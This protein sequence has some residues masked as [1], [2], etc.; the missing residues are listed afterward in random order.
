MSQK[1]EKVQKGWI[2]QSASRKHDL[3]MEVAPI[4]K[5]SLLFDIL[6]FQVKFAKLG[7]GEK[8]ER[9]KVRIAEEDEL[10]SSQ[11]F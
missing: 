3:F 1:F 10:F 5:Y 8:F 2:S 7:Q 4:P 11:I 6:L 9:K